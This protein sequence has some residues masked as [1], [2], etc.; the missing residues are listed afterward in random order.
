MNAEGNLITSLEVTTNEAYDGNHFCS[1]VDQD[2]V[3]KLPIQT[4]TAD[5]GY[6]DGHNHFYLEHQHLKSA[7]RL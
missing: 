7:I 2:L 4:Y 5:R 6:D 3:K 1:L